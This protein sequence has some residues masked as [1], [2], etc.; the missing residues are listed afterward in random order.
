MR[1][2][3]TKVVVSRKYL[4]Y[5][6]PRNTRRFMGV[7][8]KRKRQGVESG[9]TSTS[10][11][12]TQGETVGGAREEI[13]ENYKVLIL[14]DGLAAEKGRTSWAYVLFYE[15]AI[16]GFVVDFRLS[17]VFVVLGQDNANASESDFVRDDFRSYLPEQ[18]VYLMVRRGQCLQIK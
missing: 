15:P 8:S 11:A 1:P 9:S 16:R 17:F 3:H 7:D 2:T 4:L 5:V 14:M 6:S 18:S 10:S 13:T 12:T